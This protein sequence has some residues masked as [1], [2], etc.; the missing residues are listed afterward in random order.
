MHYN[1]DFVIILFV[2]VL[3]VFF[4]KELVEYGFRIIKKIKHG[5]L[6][7]AEMQ[8]VNELAEPS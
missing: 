8:N 4:K 6:S 5:H 1:Y 2:F 7:G 3:A